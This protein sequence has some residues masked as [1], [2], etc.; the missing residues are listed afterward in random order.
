MIPFLPAAENS[1][2]ALDR[3]FFRRKRAEFGQIKLFF[4]KDSHPVAF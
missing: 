2:H 3:R 4:V 1:K